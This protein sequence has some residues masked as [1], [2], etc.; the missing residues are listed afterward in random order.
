MGEEQPAPWL[1][2]GSLL[3]RAGLITPEQLELALLDQEQLRRR[4]GEILVDLGW[5]T[6][7]DVACALAEQYGLD[8]VDLSEL[9]PDPGVGGLLAPELARRYQALPLEV[10]PEGVLLVA[11]ADPTDVGACDELR[12][13]LPLPIRLVVADRIQLEEALLRL[14]EGPMEPLGS[15]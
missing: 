11:V 7:R 3:V 12:Q 4:L 8:L 10:L 15:H 1:P 9:E 2:L 5:V 6:S 13:L 14:T